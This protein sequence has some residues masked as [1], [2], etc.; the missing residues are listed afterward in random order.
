[1]CWV[2]GLKI[3]RNMLCVQMLIGFCIVHLSFLQPISRCLFKT[4]SL[5]LSRPFHS[6]ARDAFAFALPRLVVGAGSRIT[7]QA[8][9]SISG[10]QMA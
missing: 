8:T 4:N 10:A 3:P 6:A 5:N 7:M 9:G 1:M 2:G